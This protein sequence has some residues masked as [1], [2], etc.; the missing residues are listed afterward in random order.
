MIKNPLKKLERFFFNF[1][2]IDMVIVMKKN[3]STKEL[4]DT[5]KFVEELGARTHI[6]KGE[7]R[8]IIGVI[9]D[10][11][12]IQKEQLIALSGVE[13]VISILQPYKLVSREFKIRDSIVSVNGTNIGGGHPVIIAGPCSV[14]SEEQ[15]IETAK[16]VKHHGAHIIRGGAFKPRTS[17]YSFQGHGEEGL[18][19]LK[20]AK[21][22]TGLAIITEVMETSQVDLVAKYADILQVGARNMQN[23]NLL[24][25]V[26][27]INKPVLLK[28]GMSAQLTEFLMS[29]EYIMSEGNSE[30]ILCERGIRTFVDFARNTLDLNIVPAVKKISHLPI[31]VDPSHGTGRADL[32]EPMSIA[33]LAAGAD[34]LMLEVHPHPEK[35]WSDADQTLSPDQF[36]NVMKRI[37][38]FIN[39]QFIAYA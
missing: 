3:A 1:G 15:I 11:R 20:K 24:K 12:N 4:N 26:G 22:E 27:R 7:E 21:E 17:P 29:A 36:A 19:Y 16:I 34:G 18:R 13:K 9:G 30:V 8:T 6:S 2:R 23:F 33:S 25:A 14:E 37:N 32:V 39:N 10:K 38:H 5:V 28:R 35:A 31:I